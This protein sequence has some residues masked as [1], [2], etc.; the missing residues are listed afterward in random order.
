ME[1]LGLGV[2]QTLQKNFKVVGPICLPI[3]TM[4][5]FLS[6]QLSLLFKV[7][8]FWMVATLPGPRQDLQ[9]VLICLSVMTKASTHFLGTYWLL[10]LHTR[11]AAVQVTACSLLDSLSQTWTE[12]LSHPPS[13]PLPSPT[14]S[15]ISAKL[16]NQSNCSP[17]DG[18][19]NKESLAY[20]DPPP[21]F[22]EK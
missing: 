13:P 22:S 4:Q 3:N 10:Y 16:W 12:S 2:L 21:L 18:G 8:N 14:K 20:V 6:L 15:S 5:G 11:E 1:I 9:V 19:M 17:M 7:F